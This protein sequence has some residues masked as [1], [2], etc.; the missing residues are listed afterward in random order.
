MS[1]DLDLRALHQRCEPDPEFRAALRRRIAQIVSEDGSAHTDPGG[2]LVN[3]IELAPRHTSRRRPWP[4]LLIGAAA[5]VVV[6]AIA[7]MTP[8]SDESTVSSPELEAG[9]ASPF[10]A[11]IEASGVLTGPSPD[12]VEQAMNSDLYKP[13]TGQSQV[14]LAGNYVSVRTC[15]STY[16]SMRNVEP[17]PACPDG[18][19]AGWTYETGNVDGVEV[20][21]GLVGQAT[22]LDVSVLDDRYFVVVDRQ[23]Q[24]DPATPTAAWLIDAVSGKIGT[25]RWRDTPTTLGSPAQALLLCEGCSP[26]WV[27]DARDGTI[28]PL[29]VPDDAATDLPVAQPGTGRIWVGTA[30]DSGL[31]GLAYTDDGGQTWTDVALPEQLAATSEE[32]GQSIDQVLI[33]ADG[34]RVAVALLWERDTARDHLYV[35][36]DG[37]RNWTAAPFEEGGNSAHLFVLADGRLVLVWWIDNSADQ[38]F[39]S[40]GTQW[41]ALKQLDRPFDTTDIGGGTWFN[42][43]QVGVALITTRTPC[44]T[45][46]GGVAELDQGLDVTIDFSVDLTNW[47]TLRG[48]GDAPPGADDPEPAPPAASTATLAKGD[49]EITGFGSSGLNG[50]TLSIDA[51][52]QDGKATGEFRVGNVVVAIQCAGST[53]DGRDLIVGGVVTENDGAPRLDDTTVAVGDL[54]ALIIRHDGAPDGR[55][56]RVTL[57]QPSLWYGEQANEHT[58]SCIALV[59]SV[60]FNLDGGFFD[61]VDG[62][63]NIETR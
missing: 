15:R 30:P 4:A 61:D 47:T 14:S 36:D 63:G 35:S 49:V 37:G 6:T 52:Q 50:Q 18:F 46:P 29:A 56:Q 24:G 8:R 43:N 10:A 32:L 40:T 44:S 13:D 48:L 27:V 9:D 34:D 62:D 19:P 11:A 55:T 38:L 42:V 2:S 53:F 59:D 58:G 25:L 17:S 7:I 28:Q 60:P 31:L 1:D 20:H 51:E 23:D 39:V 57:Y 54:L 3:V 5:A 33:A 22:Y 45:C 16:W 12:E 21:H 41:A 26:P